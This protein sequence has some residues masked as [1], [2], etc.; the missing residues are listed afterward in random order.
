MDGRFN[1]T[2]KLLLYTNMSEYGISYK[3]LTLRGKK[4]NKG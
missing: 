1:G 3:I 4:D 2:G